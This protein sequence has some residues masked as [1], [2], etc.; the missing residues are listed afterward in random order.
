M[1]GP[2]PHDLDPRPGQDPQFRAGTEAPSSTLAQAGAVPGAVPCY[3]NGTHGYR[4]Q[5]VYAREATTTDRYDSYEAT[6]RQWAACMDD[7]VNT[8]AA[9]TAAS[10]TSAS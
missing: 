10:A 8:S 7:A 6:F 4:V 2:A 5:L 9:A 1:A 3:G